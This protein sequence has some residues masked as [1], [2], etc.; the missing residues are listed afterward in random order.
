MRAIILVITL[1]LGATHAG[2][3]LS[4]NTN[5]VS[6]LAGRDVLTNSD[7]LANDLVSNADRSGGKLAPSSGNSM[8]V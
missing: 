6:N 8:N 7:D 2:L 3:N 4:S 1:A 5:T